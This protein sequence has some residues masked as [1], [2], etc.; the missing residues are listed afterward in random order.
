[1]THPNLLRI[2]RSCAKWRGGKV[3][4]ATMFLMCSASQPNTR[5]V[6]GKPGIL[7]VGVNGV[8]T[9]GDTLVYSVSWGAGARA[10]SYDYRLSVTASNGAWAVVADSNGSGKWITGN[11]IGSLPSSSSVSFTSVKTWIAAIPWDSATFTV[12]VNSRNANGISSSVSASW[13]V[14][15]KPGPPGPIT[16][17]SS[18]IVT[19]TLVLPDSSNI[20]LGASRIVC[21]FKQFGNG[22]VTQWTADKPSCDS[23]YTKYVPL[24]SRTKVTVAQQVHT[25]SLSKTCVVWSTTFTTLQLTPIANCS[26]AV[27]VTGIGLTRRFP[28]D[29]IR[30]ALR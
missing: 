20:G 30:Y 11:G 15:R 10:T 21:G 19:A 8:V 24:A 25:D 1:M 27:R 23:I 22:A 29:A 7:V 28:A 5:P 14:N 13:K 2:V 4:V 6:P 18:L 17:D 26:A 12:S 16:I 3:L 9:A